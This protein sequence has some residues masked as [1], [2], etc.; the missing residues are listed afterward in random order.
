MDYLNATGQG[1]KV[2]A[3]WDEI[4][5]EGNR[6]LFGFDI[7]GGVRLV[8]GLWLPLNHSPNE[9]YLGLFQFRERRERQLAQDRGP[10]FKAE[11]ILGLGNTG[12]WSLDSCNLEVT[13][14][15]MRCFER[16]HAV[17][18]SVAI[19]NLIRF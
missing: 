16:L 2:S 6:V 10:G 5:L 4:H 12:F 15:L 11:M 14:K 7:E 17:E 8:L 3:E 13:G 9:E 1:L 19:E 18:S